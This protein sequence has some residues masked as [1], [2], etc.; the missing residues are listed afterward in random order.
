MTF[1]EGHGFFLLFFFEADCFLRLLENRPVGLGA[2]S[3]Q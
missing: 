2:Y 1:S 3:A